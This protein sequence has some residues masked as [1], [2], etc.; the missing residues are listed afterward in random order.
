MKEGHYTMIKGSIEQ[1]DLTYI[2]PQH[3]ISKVQKANIN[4]LN[5]ETKTNTI[6]AGTLIPYLTAM[7][8]PP[9][10]KTNKETWQ[11]IILS[12]SGGKKSSE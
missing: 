1:E 4:K 5:G 12:L 11:K 7:D 8:R 3:R 10:Q 9:R 6:I 2:S